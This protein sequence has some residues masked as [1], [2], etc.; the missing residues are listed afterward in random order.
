LSCLLLLPILLCFSRSTLGR[1]K[2]FDREFS[3]S[4]IT[5]TVTFGRSQG[6]FGSHSLGRGAD[7]GIS[8][9]S[10]RRFSCCLF[11][12]LSLSCFLC[13]AV[14][15]LLLSGY[16]RC[17]LGCLLGCAVGCL[18]LCLQSRFPLGR[19]LGCS[20]CCLSCCCLLC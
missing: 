3:G 11:G 19:L 10:L 2:L 7:G 12:C 8:L 1:R 4:A 14:G 13:R 15:S 18:F 16:S 6:P 17:L 5:F 20:F 9:S